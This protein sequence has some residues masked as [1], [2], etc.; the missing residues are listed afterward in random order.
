LALREHE[1]V[2]IETFECLLKP[3][4]VRH[5][6]LPVYDFSRLHS[7]EKNDDRVNER[8]EDKDDDEEEEEEEEVEEKK[9]SK[10]LKR[11]SERNS[12]KTG[13]KQQQEKVTKNY[14]F[15]YPMS[16]I[17]GHTGFITIAAL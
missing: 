8:D 13:D 3:Y 2:E 5:S 10:K 11:E 16:Q 6:S 12:N 17:A 4:E 1:F 9:E 15:A 14:S 7:K